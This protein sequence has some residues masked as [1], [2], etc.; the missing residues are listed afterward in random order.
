VKIQLDLNRPRWLRAPRT[1]RGRVLVVAAAAVIVGVPVAWAAHDFADVPNANPHHT[2]ISRIKGAGITGGCNPPANTLY[3]PDQFVRR[4]QM[5]SFLSRGNPRVAYTQAISDSTIEFSTTFPTDTQ[6][7]TVT[8]QV[9]GVSGATQFVQVHAHMR[10]AQ[11]VGAAP[12]SLG[13]YIARPSCADGA[14]PANRSPIFTD[15]IRDGLGHTFSASW[16]MPVQPGGRIFNLCAYTLTSGRIASVS[17]ANIVA[18]SVPHGASGGAVL[19]TPAEITSSDSR[20][21]D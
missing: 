5:A 11:S 3:C 15:A 18:S 8:I 12:Y 9:P 14:T 19:G 16:V 17:A 1:W 20:P 6:V 10:V 13:F 4:D 7:A 21:T 2:D